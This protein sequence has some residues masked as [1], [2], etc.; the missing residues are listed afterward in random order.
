[1]TGMELATEMRPG[2]DY[3]VLLKRAMPFQVM[4]N[5]MLEKVASAARRVT[6]RAGER[7]YERGERA[8]DLFV[9]VS[10]QVEHIMGPGAGA[11]NLLRN[12]EAGE[13][14]GWAALLTSQPY[15]LAKAT[16]AQD[17]EC[18]A[19]ST[20]ALLRILESAPETG[21]VVMSRFATMITR[22]Y[23][24][25]DWMAKVK[26]IERRQQQHL[27]GTALTMYRLAQWLK[28]PR[29]YLM[30]I[31]FSLLLGFW[32]MAV[33]VWKLPR[34][35]QMPGL[36]S[37]VKEWTSKDPVYG[38]SLYTPEYYQHIWVS[39]RRV[40]IAFFLA[41]ALGVPLGLFLGWSQKFK[42]YVFPVFEMLRPIP[43]LAWVP[44][45]I[46]M[47]S[48]L[49]TPVLFLA[50]LASFYATALNTMLGVQ[51]I[52]ES[53]FRAGY[54]LGANRWQVFRHVIVPGSMP[55]IFTGLQISIGVCWF[56]LVA[57]E[58]VSGQFGLGYVI[59]NSYTTVRYPTIVIGMVTLG[60][61][62]YATSA[63]VRLA[64]DYMM[65]WR[66]RELALGGT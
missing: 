23:S 56:S 57:A 40:G 24:V 27:T 35:S 49:E 9:I 38:L 42:E 26:P 37:V 62:G 20:Q 13:V 50:F 4:S 46:L 64:G 45:A 21:N 16:A 19:I 33:E 60:A 48:G 44:L 11:T 29:P 22:D 31:G 1:M 3:V 10:G 36:T 66:V 47:F 55:Y 7:I 8:D 43:I 12:L 61:V 51:S 25:P 28:S 5:D 52:D 58:M 65:Q 41:T 63:L 6:Y 59:N 14:F 30:F 18:L 54:C 32:Y 39:C 15:R 34:F 53:Y 17:T 2:E